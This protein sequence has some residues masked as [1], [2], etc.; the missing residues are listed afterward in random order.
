[1]IQITKLEN[2]FINQ[3]T[4]A[5]VN[6]YEITSGVQRL[7]DTFIITLTGIYD[8]SDPQLLDLVYARLHDIGYEI[9]VQSSAP[10]TPTTTGSLDTE[11]QNSIDQAAAE[12]TAQGL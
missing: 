10:T 1:M 5:T 7:K 2:D 4:I 12:A 9:I 8:I 6:I 11:T 3:Y